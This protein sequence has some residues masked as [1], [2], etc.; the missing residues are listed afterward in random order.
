MKIDRKIIEDKL[1]V[2]DELKIINL[3]EQKK[4]LISKIKDCGNT[5]NSEISGSYIGDAST[6]L[7]RYKL[8]VECLKEIVA[9]L[10][11]LEAKVKSSK[12]TN[13][14][15]LIEEIEAYDN[16]K[17]NKRSNDDDD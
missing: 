17:K 3:R 7:S 10:K 9:E 1:E 13:G 8:Y 11:K 15:N 4:S 6:A 12:T 2:S 14:F 16:E 5:V